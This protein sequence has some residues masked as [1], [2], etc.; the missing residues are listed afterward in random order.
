MARLQTD[1]VRIKTDA[2]EL[3]KKILRAA[4]SA[5]M[6]F[7]IFFT[8]FYAA[9]ATVRHTSIMAQFYGDIIEL[10]M[11]GDAYVSEEATLKKVEKRRKANAK[12]T[13]P[14]FYKSLFGFDTYK[15]KGFEVCTYEARNSNR[16][17]VY[18][19]GG[20]YMWQPLATHFSYC[21]Y[22][23]KELNVNVI[24][25]IYPK[26]PQYGYEDALAWTYDF[27][28]TLDDG[29]DVVAFMGDSAGGGLM[30]SF[31]QYLTDRGGTPPSDL[32]AFSPCLELSLQNEEIAEFTASDPM[33]NV[34]DLRRKL[35][36]YVPDGDFE[37]PYASAIYCDYENFEEVT[38]FVGTREIL[39]PDVRR[40]IGILEEKSV[41]HNYY[42][43]ENLYHTFSI[44][45][46]PERQECLNVIK[47]VLDN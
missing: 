6:V 26:A 23:R 37:N 32:I 40:L 16:T 29:Y 15:Y 19:H 7:L 43:Y 24:I 47:S 13:V 45:P 17:I 25:P 46:M 33:L 10:F 34:D 30:F 3:K 2:A 22:L 4:L 9:Y 42:E 14:D 41:K 27:Y 8:G 1:K 28:Q 20:S 35:S 38:V 5:V 36:F 11:T 39:L 31:A 12:Y 18:F 21:D 44:M